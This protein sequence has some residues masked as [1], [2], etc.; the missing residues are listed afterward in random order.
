MS[1]KWEAVELWDISGNN[2]RILHRDRIT[3]IVE[4]IPPPIKC[5]DWAWILRPIE[6]LHAEQVCGSVNPA[7]LDS[8][9]SMAK[10]NAEAVIYARQERLICGNAGFKMRCI[11]GLCKRDAIKA[12]AAKPGDILIFKKY[13]W[14]ETFTYTLRKME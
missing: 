5:S 1:N 10:R 6:F 12:F 8:D 3:G 14:G 2:E 7:N 11:T 13:G 9:D 4:I